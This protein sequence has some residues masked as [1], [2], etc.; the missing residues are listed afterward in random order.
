M[1][2]AAI[3]VGH[4]KKP[5][6]EVRAALLRMDETV[7][8]PELLRQMIAYIPDSTEVSFAHTRLSRRKGKHTKYAKAQGTSIPDLKTC[9]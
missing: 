5:T 6:A 3:L 9:I 7:L 8:T 4:L 1:F 2:L